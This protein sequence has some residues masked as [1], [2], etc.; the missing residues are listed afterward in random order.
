MSAEQERIIP[1]GPASADDLVAYSKQ[2]SALRLNERTDWVVMAAALVA[3]IDRNTAVL[4]ALLGLQRG[5]AARSAQHVHPRLTALA[6]RLEQ[7][8]R[9]ITRVGDMAQERSDE[10]LTAV[11]ELDQAIRGGR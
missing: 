7:L 6:E 3:A 11:R 5:S 10:V 4:D 2:L 8:E 1:D 9:D